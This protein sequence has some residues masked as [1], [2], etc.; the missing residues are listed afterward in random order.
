MYYGNDEHKD[1]LLL[2]YFSSFN[3]NAD[4]ELQLLMEMSTFAQM[5]QSG[6]KSKHLHIYVLNSLDKCLY[7][8]YEFVSL[9]Y[10]NR[11][12]GGINI[13]CTLYDEKFAYFSFI[14]KCSAIIF[15]FI[16]DKFQFCTP[17][18]NQRELWSA[19]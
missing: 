6:R 19:R 2:L 11:I 9:I 1:T 10:K 16:R 7:S 14:L 15:G 8:I 5:V 17:T 13:S 4:L 12:K 18:I 3:R